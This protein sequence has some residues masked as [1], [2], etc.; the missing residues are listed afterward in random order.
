ML[1][2]DTSLFRICV[3]SP[4]ALLP[5]GNGSREYRLSVRR[6]DSYQQDLQK[7]AATTG[8]RYMGSTSTLTKAFSQL[9]FAISGMLCT[10]SSHD[11]AR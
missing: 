8:S 4:G 1:A 6:G 7:V 2:H 10:L 11:E 5:A 9:Y 3:P